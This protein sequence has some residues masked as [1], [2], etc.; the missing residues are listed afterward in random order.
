[1]IIEWVS[2][3][4][5]IELDDYKELS[6][7]AVLLIKDEEN[8]LVLKG[9]VDE[10]SLE[11]EL[12]IIEFLELRKFPVQTPLLH[13]DGEFLL[14][15]EEAIYCVYFYLE[16]RPFSASE[17]LRD[18]EVP[19]LLGETIANM[20]QQLAKKHDLTRY[21]N[22]DF[23]QLVFGF[24]REQIV[25][26]N[27]PATFVQ[28]M[29]E[30]EPSIRFMNVSLPKQLIHRDAHI[31]NMIF[32]DYQLSW[33]IDFELAEVNLKLFDL[34]YCATGVLS[35]VYQDESL[36]EVWID[37]V[38]HL[39]AGYHSQC[40]LTKEEQDSIWTMMLCIQMIF[41]AYFKGDKELVASNQDMFLWIYSKREEIGSMKL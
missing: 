19:N 39:V 41:M 11:R 10:D 8:K 24:A 4:Y 27:L 22:K 3:N 31:H 1:M 37:F 21:E 34:C 17:S 9:K 40:P 35:E 2:R 15:D 23:Y 14:Q 29:D 13:A 6:E 30:L 7:R 32:Q 28:Q 38:N 36:R 26:M 20:H 12:E 5:G 18:K 33:V 25:S 16:G